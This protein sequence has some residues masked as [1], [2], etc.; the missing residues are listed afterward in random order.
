ML[1]SPVSGEK[2]EVKPT[3][4]NEKP[5]ILDSTIA[6]MLRSPVSGEKLR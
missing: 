5:G 4:L 1:R 6:V 2:T 3:N